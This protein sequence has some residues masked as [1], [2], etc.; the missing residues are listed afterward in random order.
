MKKKRLLIWLFAL[1]GLPA[2][3]QYVVTVGGVLETPGFNDGPALSARF[4]NP[5]GIDVDSAGNVYVADRFNHTIRKITADGQVITLAGKAGVKGDTDGPALSARFNEPWGLCVDKFGN[6]FVADTRNNKIRKITPNGTVTT[7]AGSGNFGSS[8]GVGVTASFGNPTGIDVDDQGNLYVADHLTH[9][10]RKITPQGQVT[11]IAGFPYIPGDADG[12]GTGAQFWRPYGLCLDNDGNIIVADEWNHKI[13]KVTPDGIVTTIAGTGEPG[14]V[15]GAATQA[16]FNYPWDVTVDG[17]GNIYVGDGYNYVVRKITP[18]G[19]VTTVAGT[20]LEI[21]GSDGPALEATFGGVTGLSWRAGSGEIFLAD[22]YNNLVRKLVLEDSSLTLLNLTPPKVCANT[23]IHLQ[24]AP[25]YYD[26]YRFFVNGDLVQDSG[27]PVFLANNWTP[28]TYDIYVESAYLGD[29]LI[30]NTVT[31]TVLPDAEPTISVVGDLTF[32]EGDSVTLVASGSG[33]FLWNTGDTTQSITVYE[34]GEYWVEVYSDY[35]CPGASDPVTVTVLPSPTTPQVTVEGD[36]LLC[37]GESTLLISS[38]DQNVQ[39]YRDGWPIDGAQSPQLIVTQAG[40]YQVQATDPNSGVTAFSEEVIIDQAEG[41]LFDFS[42]LPATSAHTGDTLWF[43][44][45]GSDT[46]YYEWSFGDGAF[47]T[48]LETF[49]RYDLAGTF[50]VSLLAETVEGCRDTLV[51]QDYITITDPGNTG[52]TGGNNTG[53]TT[54]PPP[55]P[56]DPGTDTGELFI[57]TA[58]TP[59]GDGRNDRFRPRGAIDGTF[60]MYIFNQ[61]GEQIY[62]T[63]DPVAG[64]DGTRNGLPVHNGTYVYLI[65]IEPTGEPRRAYSGHVTLIR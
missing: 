42:V 6:V 38:F 22:A 62:F 19:F 63:Q 50:D 2:M 52:N 65:Y 24:A 39:W 49:H 44:A 14:H 43:Y 15:N 55:P 7:F 36:T 40:I 41:P 9:I 57:P 5:H 45:D 8:D 3:A 34:S 37:P 20:P 60:R 54:T 27:D 59:N 29:L 58:F 31:I 51:K 35:Y 1:I 18:Q 16:Q 10:I 11:T 13:R 64:W 26:F 4:F 61:W 33:V 21:G 30:S 53:G 32:Y 46:Y 23:T 28:G 25:D 47:G 17:N 56:P 12:Q 48:G